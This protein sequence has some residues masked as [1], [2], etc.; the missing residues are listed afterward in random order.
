M[1]GLDSLQEQAVSR[2][3]YRN[4]YGSIFSQHVI[5]R[6]NFDETTGNR[7]G[8]VMGSFRF[9]SNE[10]Q[11]RSAARL[12]RHPPACLSRLGLLSVPIIRSVHTGVRSTL[13]HDRVRIKTRVGLGWVGLVWVG[14]PPTCYLDGHALQINKTNRTN[15]PPNLASNLASRL[16]KLSSTEG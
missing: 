12:A 2:C 14:S 11:T 13:T 5:H 3:V 8:R 10:H 9:P 7:G 15:R 16:E 6:S 4:P 1:I